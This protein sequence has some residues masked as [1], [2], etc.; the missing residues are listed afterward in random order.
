MEPPVLPSSESG[1]EGEESA[2]QTPSLSPAWVCLGSRGPG[3]VRPA[4]TRSCCSLGSRAPPHWLE[5]HAAFPCGCAFLE[6]PPALILV[7][8]SHC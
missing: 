5:Q 3:C 1:N 6:A 4:G 2:S 8:T 7:G